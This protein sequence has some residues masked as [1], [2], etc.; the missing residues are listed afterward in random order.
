MEASTSSADPASGQRGVRSATTDEEEKT[1][2][3]AAGAAA[4][5]PAVWE[6]REVQLGLVDYGEE[7][8]DEQEEVD[9]ENP[10][11]AGLLGEHQAR[12]HMGLSV[13]GFFKLVSV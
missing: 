3:A 13:F 8:G 1:A 9:V 12:E 7:E 6:A 11:A 5:S 10:E 4:S 2:H